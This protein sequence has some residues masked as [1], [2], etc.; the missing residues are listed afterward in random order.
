LQ[1]DGK[2]APG[3]SGA[4]A[5]GAAGLGES[6][7]KAA[8]RLLAALGTPEASRGPDPTEPYAVI[9]RSVRNGVS[10]GAGRF[11]VEAAVS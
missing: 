3:R 10:L 6:L 4:S 5:G 7:S 2:G 9:V 8:E 1:S 11:P